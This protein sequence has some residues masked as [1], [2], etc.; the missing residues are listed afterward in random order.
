MTEFCLLRTQW[1]I[2]VARGF[3]TSTLIADEQFQLLWPL[4]FFHPAHIWAIIRVMNIT[5]HEPRNTALHFRTA[6]KSRG[7]KGSKWWP[8]SAHPWSMHLLSF[9][10]PSNSNTQQIVFPKYRRSNTIWLNKNQIFTSGRVGAAKSGC[11]W[12]SIHFVFEARG[13]ER[14]HG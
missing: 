5:E 4:A 11:L 9:A 10:G 1:V 6:N 2:L 13:C 14:R 3:V 12:E 7:E 8:S